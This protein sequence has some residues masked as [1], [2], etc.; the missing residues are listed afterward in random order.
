MKK[1]LSSFLV[2]V[3]LG[4]CPLM[5]MGCRMVATNTSVEFTVASVE[6]GVSALSYEAVV[7]EFTITATADPE[8]LLERVF[9]D[10]ARLIKSIGRHFVPSRAANPT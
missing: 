6:E 10:V 2:L 3:L 5:S 7:P 9:A 1:L 8:A 4:G